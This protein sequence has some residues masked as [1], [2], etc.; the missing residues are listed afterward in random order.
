M[1]IQNLAAFAY[2]STLDL[3]SAYYN[4][5]LDPNTGSRIGIIS[6]FGNF[7]FLTLPFSLESSPAIFTRFMR[8]ILTGLQYDEEQ[9]FVQAYINDIV[10]ASKESVSHLKL[11]EQIFELLC[12][13]DLILSEKK[14]Y[15]CEDSIEFLGYLIQ[16]GKRY[17]SPSKTAALQNWKLPTTAKDWYSFIGFANFLSCFIPNCSFLLK[18]L[19]VNHTHLVKKLASPIEPSILLNN[20]N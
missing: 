11:V 19:Y 9:H 8:F 18:R 20:F 13:Y 10:V 16:D 2:F 3:K 17:P 12:K 7:E 1:L 6:H 5:P 4:V 15:L 14:V